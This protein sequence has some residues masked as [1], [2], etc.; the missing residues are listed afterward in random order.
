MKTKRERIGN[1]A[2]ITGLLPHN[3]IVVAYKTPFVVNTTKESK[4]KKEKKYELVLFRSY[5][6]KVESHL[7]SGNKTRTSV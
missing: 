5:D 4:K 3:S 2:S 1:K 6:A 7:P